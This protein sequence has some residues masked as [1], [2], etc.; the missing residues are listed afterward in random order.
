V[1]PSKTISVLDVHLLLTRES[2]IY[3]HIAQDREIQKLL[4]ASCDPEVG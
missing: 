4:I 2:S 1:L 3:L